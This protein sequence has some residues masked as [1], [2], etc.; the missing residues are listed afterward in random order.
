[1]SLLLWFRASYY[2]HVQRV[3]FQGKVLFEHVMDGTQRLGYHHIAGQ[4]FVHGD[5][6]SISWPSPV[7]QMGRTVHQL[8][9]A[10]RV[11]RFHAFHA[12]NR[13][14]SRWLCGH[15]QYHEETCRRARA[16]YSTCTQSVKGSMVGA[17]YS[18]ACY[19]RMRGD[20]VNHGCP[21]CGGASTPNLEHLVWHCDRFEASRPP[22]PQD[23]MAYP[24]AW[25]WRGALKRQVDAIAGHF[26]QVG[27]VIRA[28]DGFF[29]LRAEPGAAA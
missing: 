24:L 4:G 10:W 23:R 17:T 28:R 2:W 21:F 13:R 18:S 15:V 26:E 3:V 14:D 12:K 5:L 11:Q 29:S 9:E 7:G 19:S 20:A 25:P 1:M 22:A 27:K 8:R 16:L 6:P